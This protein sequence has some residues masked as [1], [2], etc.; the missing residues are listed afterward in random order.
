MIV[1]V[2]QA[3][4]QERPVQLNGE[5]SL[6]I[7]KEFTL[8][9]PAT[10]SG[11]C[12]CLGDGLFLVSGTLAFTCSTP[13]ARCLKPTEIGLSIAFEERF[14]R[15]LTAEE[16]EIYPYTG[17][18]IDLGPA[19]NEAANM[20]LPLR[21]LCEED[22]KGTM[23]CVRGGQKRKRVRVPGGVGQRVFGC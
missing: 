16:D 11:Q 5:V 6:D 17:N 14:A 9:Q 21:V 10:F 4:I 1:P 2:R 19:L 8:L 18:E 15:E 13:C 12:Q 22:C 23:P 3:N 7:P 20:S